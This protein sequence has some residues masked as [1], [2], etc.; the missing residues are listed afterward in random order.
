[1]ELTSE[2][3]VQS[4]AYAEPSTSQD[5]LKRS[6]SERK[7]TEAVCKAKDLNEAIAESD[8]NITS[9]STPKRRRYIEPRYVDEIRTPDVATPR[10]ARR[11]IKLVKRVNLVKST[12]IKKLQDKNRHLTKQVNSLRQLLQHLRSKGL[13]D[14]NSGEMLMVNTSK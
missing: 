1:M 10:K 7:I 11:V 8:R 12:K 9:T 5:S 14:E 2:D 3:I 13:M 6:V 4:V